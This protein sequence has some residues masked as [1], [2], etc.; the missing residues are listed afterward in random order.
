MALVLALAVCGLGGE[1][2]PLARVKGLS[3]GS[4]IPQADSNLQFPAFVVVKVS[5]G[6]SPGHPFHQYFAVKPGPVWVQLSGTRKCGLTAPDPESFGARLEE[7]GGGGHRLSY[8]VGS[9]ERSRV[10]DESFFGAWIVA[11]SEAAHLVY[12]ISHGST[13]DRHQ[14]LY[15]FDEQEGRETPIAYAKWALASPDQRWVF[16]GGVAPA[17]PG[18]GR[19]F[20][21]AGLY[22]YDMETRK[23]W[24]LIDDGAT[25]NLCH[26]E[27]GS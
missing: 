3:R 16:F 8:K 21:A 25:Y 27:T 5:Q 22:L 1:E 18:S 13:S 17:W 11:E 26:W 19:S 14:V 24:K 6:R 12:S 9:A 20:R 15:D 7:E 10:L 23:A 4:S 2:L